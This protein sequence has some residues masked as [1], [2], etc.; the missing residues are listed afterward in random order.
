MADQYQRA[1]EELIQ[2]YQRPWGALIARGRRPLSQNKAAKAI[3]ISPARWRQIENGYQTV[4]HGQQIA[5]EG[6]AETVARMARSVGVTSEQLRQAGRE[7]A[8][9]ALDA[10][11]GPTVEVQLDDESSPLRRLIGIRDEI[12]RVIE[13]LRAEAGR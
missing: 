12:D 2:R 6:P 7:D 10:L 13:D 5:V 8:A 11:N 3:G 9:T 1:D 4:G